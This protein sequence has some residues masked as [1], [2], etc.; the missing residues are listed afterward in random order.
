MDLKA[1]MRVLINKV[2]NQMLKLHRF[3]LLMVQK[4]ALN[5]RF[6]WLKNKR[7]TNFFENLRRFKLGRPQIWS[8]GWISCWTICFF[9]LVIVFIDNALVSPWVL[10]VQSIWQISISLPMSLIS[11]SVSWRVIR[12]VVLHRLSLGELFVPDFPD[13]ENFTY[14]NQDSFGSGLYTQKHLVSW[15]VNLK[16]SLLISWI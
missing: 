9:V 16:A 8:L 13:F 7:E 6:L 2:F 3:K 4:P 1:R 10:I 5:F 11:L 15:I 14:L 12:P